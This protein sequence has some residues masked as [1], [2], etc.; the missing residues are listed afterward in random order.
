MLL[1]VFQQGVGP[2]AGPPAGPP[3]ITSQ[4]GVKKHKP[5]F[6]RIRLSELDA[7]ERKTNAEFIK[8]FLALPETERAEEEGQEPAIRAGKKTP[9][10]IRAEA[11]LLE[12]IRIEKED[13]IR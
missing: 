11:A 12:A 3:V 2:P 8:S 10:Q 4:P 9:D 1:V 7:A 5:R 13:E 6:I